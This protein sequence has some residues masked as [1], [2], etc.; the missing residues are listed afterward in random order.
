MPLV[1]KLIFFMGGIRFTIILITLFALSVCAG[2]VIE[3]KTGSHKIASRLIYSNPF[4]LMILW[5]I[6]LNI[7]FAT[8]KRY[9]FQKK[10]IPFL[11]THLGLLMIFGGSLLKISFGLQGTLTLKE[12]LS[13][14]WVKLDD[15]YALSF[16]K[17]G[18]NAWKQ[19]ALQRDLFGRLKTSYNIG[20]IFISLKGFLP[21][22]EEKF[23]SW[24]KDGNL[25]FLGNNPV[26]LEKATSWGKY[27][28]IAAKDPEVIKRELK[29]LPA[30]VFLEEPSGLIS[31]L[32]VNEKGELK[33]QTY[34]PA[35]LKDLYAYDE[36]FGGYTAPFFLAAGEIEA[37]LTRKFKGLPSPVK[38]EEERPLV[39]IGLE[40]GQVKDQLT[41]S[42]AS[43]LAS[44]ALQG[45][46]LVRFEPLRVKMDERIK[47]KQ[48]RAT[49]HPNTNN[50][51]S[52]TAEIMA[53]NNSQKLS[54]N[55]VWENDSGMRFYLANMSPLDESVVKEVRLVVNHDPF[56]RILTYPG[57]I[58]LALG[59]V[60]LF[61][62]LPGRKPHS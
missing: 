32:E 21:H 45:E 57:A 19:V 10:H 16:R 33:N 53:G 46:Y 7:L 39:S 1:K 49:T 61:S 31:A 59:I 35:N 17:K 62:G 36:G 8:F 43:P 24:F 30:L 6:F 14:D 2:T 58:I 12:G 27:T 11:I 18:E 38:A 4:F 44:A 47:L 26:P 56:K 9:P 28:I 29:S 51:A 60:L 34:D 50:P 3:S 41:L 15:T 54:M 55:E 37:P 42:F 20:D 5:G 40:S 48:A 13:S 52:Y 22:G 25:V 23:E